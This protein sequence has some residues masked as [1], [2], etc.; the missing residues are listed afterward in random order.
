MAISY[1]SHSSLFEILQLSG[2]V[3]L[4]YILLS[5]IFTSLYVNSLKL[6]DAYIHI[7]ASLNWG[8]H[9]FRWW[10]V[11]RLMPSHYLNSADVSLTVGNR[12]KYNCN[13]NSNVFIKEKAFRFEI[14]ICKIAI[15]FPSIFVLMFMASCCF[16]LIYK[17]GQLP[18]LDTEIHPPFS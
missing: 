3:T 1:I 6:G 18:G 2:F 10:L 15:F 13:W 16:L 7:C 12:L 8:H 9:W 14:V 4:I 11:A 5:G 17:I